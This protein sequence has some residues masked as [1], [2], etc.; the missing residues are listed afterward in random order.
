MGSPTTCLHSQTTVVQSRKQ[1]N[2]VEEVFLR[3][4][5]RHALRASQ[6]MATESDPKIPEKRVV[7]ML[8]MYARAG[9]V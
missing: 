9:F 8:Q 5:K 6:R 7:K 2:Q 1:N 3:R 4:L